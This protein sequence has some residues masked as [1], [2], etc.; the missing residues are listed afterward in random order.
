MVLKGGKLYQDVPVGIIC[1]ESH[2]AKPKGHLR[3]HYTFNFP[4]VHKVLKNIDIPRLLFNPTPD[5]LEPFIQAAKD[6]EAEGV[7]A[8]TGSCGFMAR[9]QPE[10]AAA[11]NI[12]VL[13][14]SLLQV[15][16]VR[17]MHGV[18]A[19][20]GVLTASNKALTEAHFN[21]VHSDINHVV[22]K[23]MEGYDY[24]WDTIIEGKN[25]DIDLDRMEK[26]VCDA[27]EVLAKENNLDALILE[28]TDLP[29]FSHAVHKRVGLPVYDIN[30][31]IEYAA[32]C[33]RRP[34]YRK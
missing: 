1:L 6:L 7:K 33:V 22:I 32:F 31:L 2:F 10:L 34:N 23:G 27:A 5:L 15:P 17:T 9:F 13:V 21:G 19:K 3:N 14:S 8:I 25:N 16:L 4:T 24:F 30:A 26:E 12:P 28:C 11:V 18:D 20:I 29:A